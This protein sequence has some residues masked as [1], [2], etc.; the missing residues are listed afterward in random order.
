[1]AAEIELKRINQ[2]VSDLVEITDVEGAYVYGIND[3][4][5]SVKI[6]VSTI[7]AEATDYSSAIN[8]LTQLCNGNAQLIAQLQNALTGKSNVGH[9][10]AISDVNGL[11]TELSGVKDRLQA[12]EDAE[13]DIDSELS[14][15]SEN[16][17][18]NK[19]IKSALDTLDNKIDNKPDSDTTYS[20]GDGI[21]ISGNNNAVSVKI[22]NDTIKLVNGV[23]KA[24]P[25][26]TVDSSL[27]ETSEN[28][29]Q[30]KIIKTEL[31]GLQSQIDEKPDTDTTYS[32]GSGIEI[33]A[34]NEVSV[35][36]DGDTVQLD[37]QGRLKAAPAVTVDSSLS[38]TSENPVQ[39]KVIK[40][41]LDKKTTDSDLATVAKT[42]DYNDLN[43]LPEIRTN[44]VPKVKNLDDYAAED[45]EIVMYEGETNEDYENGGFYKYFGGTDFVIPAGNPYLE[46]Y[47][48]YPLCKKGYLKLLNGTPPN[49]PSQIYNH[50]SK[51]YVNASTS[52]YK[53]YL[54]ADGDNY[55][56]RALNYYSS[57]NDLKGLQVGDLLCDEED[58]L[59][60]VKSIVDTVSN[61]SGIITQVTVVVH[62]YRAN[63]S[64]LI[65]QYK[66]N[67]YVESAEYLASQDFTY[68]IV[69]AGQT[70]TIDQFS[71]LN[72]DGKVFVSY[73]L[74]L[75]IM[76][77]PRDENDSESEWICAGFFNK[78]GRAI[79]G[80][81]DLGNKDFVYVDSARTSDLR[82]RIMTSN[83]DIVVSKSGWK[84]HYTQ[85]NPEIPEPEP[86]IIPDLYIDE[87]NMELQL[88][89]GNEVFSGVDLSFLAKDA[90]L[91]NAELITTPE[92]GVELELPYFKFTFNADSSTPV[93]RVSLAAFGSSIKFDIDA[94]LSEVSENP[95]QNAVIT[96][97]LS[98]KANSTDLETLQTAFNQ[99]VNEN[100]LESQL[101]ET[102]TNGVQNRI[103]TAA[104][105]NLQRQINGIKIVGG[106]KL[107]PNL[108]EYQGYTGEIVKYSGTTTQNY[109][110]G[111]DYEFVGGQT[112]ATITI[113]AGAKVITFYHPD[114]TTETGYELSNTELEITPYLIY[115]NTLTVTAEDGGDYTDA[116]KWNVGGNRITEIGKAGD[117]IIYDETH[118]GEILR[119]EFL[120]R[121]RIGSQSST[122]FTAIGNDVTDALNVV[123]SAFV[124]QGYAESDINVDSITAAFWQVQMDDG[125][126]YEL[127][128]SDRSG[129]G[130]QP[131]LTLLRSDGKRLFCQSASTYY[132]KCIYIASEFRILPVFNL[133]SHG[134]IS[135]GNKYVYYL[136]PRYNGEDTIQMNSNPHIGTYNSL[137]VLSEPLTLTV[138]DVE[139]DEYGQ[140]H[141][142]ESGHWEQRNAQPDKLPVYEEQTE[143]LIF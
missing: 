35:K 109:V 93:I 43:N 125:H 139:Y 116:T 50:K 94:Y 44:F 128:T 73:G 134:V 136:D 19:V 30:N 80:Y 101:K 9:Q 129:Q 120:F 83:T 58:N 1:M 74:Y 13:L 126:T 121:V 38:A 95:V 138:P 91:Q 96:A 70:R 52:R 41:E 76:C 28:P 40:A 11:N 113:P 104:V 24:A 67:I 39:N 45:G 5:N 130:E 140:P 53:Q 14:E 75:A 26:V 18:Q 29:V 57:W 88:R 23:L 127:T 135:L 78:T 66:S 51:E 17:V 81:Q 85:P 132:N 102:S 61:D 98:A 133:M 72:E 107:V 110:H 6:A 100:F 131:A 106:M 37:G 79:A 114:G 47:N 90:V 97:A 77:C 55:N 82:Y 118:E 108:D 54:T 111:Y 65:H 124:Q 137:A 122:E 59:Y 21:N 16:P 105:N 68:D 62:L 49:S 22:D 15:T 103:I 119:I 142:S 10:H 63:T 20:A 115:P 3:N 86:Q 99:Y 69:K 143:T 123:L 7:A 84:R 4:G 92:V 25:A 112:T 8:T 33:N 12:L 60:T 27:S 31:D 46:L 36:I 56:Y 87:K 117:L 42:G 34:S 71:V 2:Y 32:A 89:K 64:V 48:D 141:E